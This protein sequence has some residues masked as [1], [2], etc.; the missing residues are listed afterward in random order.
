M[1]TTIF[2]PLNTAFYPFPLWVPKDGSF[3]TSSDISF[4]FDT[5]T[6]SDLA[7]SG[8]RSKRFSTGC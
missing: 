4:D 3:F 6:G 1:T 8:L 5:T 2:F 7:L